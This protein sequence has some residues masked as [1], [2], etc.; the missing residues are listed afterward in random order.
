MSCVHRNCASLYI[1]YRPTGNSHWVSER[2]RVVLAVDDRSI[3][4]DDSG[5]IFSPPPHTQKQ[6]LPCMSDDLNGWLRIQ[7]LA[8]QTLANTRTNTRSH[9]WQGVLELKVSS[10]CHNHQIITH[11]QCYLVANTKTMLAGGSPMF[12]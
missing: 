3:N 7:T 9:A 8:H 12:T 6:L 11:T 2:I 1:L 4:N 5:V 10:I